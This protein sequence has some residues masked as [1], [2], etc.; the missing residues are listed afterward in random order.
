MN[1]DFIT[2]K[3]ILPADDFDEDDELD[4][5]LA[6]IEAKKRSHIDRGGFLSTQ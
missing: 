6:K 2:A 5:R 3:I 4:I 1:N